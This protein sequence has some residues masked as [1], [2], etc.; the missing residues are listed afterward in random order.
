MGR[1]LANSTE[2]KTDI[3][4]NMKII[5]I[6]VLM[7]IGGWLGWWLGYHVGIFTALVC[8][9]LGSGLGLYAGRRFTQLYDW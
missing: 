5:I 6:S 4:N 3:L 9:M 7:T 1:K 8:S 2:K